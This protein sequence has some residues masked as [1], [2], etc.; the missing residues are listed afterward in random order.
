MCYVIAWRA[1]GT[2]QS[3]AI[4]GAGAMGGVFGAL[5]SEA[6][7][8]TTLIDANPQLVDTINQQGITLEE[9]AGDRT[10]R[11]PARTDIADLD[12]PDAVLFFVKCQHT[13]AAAETAR[14]LVADGT[15]VVTL[16]NGWGNAEVLTGA[17][18]EERVVVGVTYTS[19]TTIAPARI[20]TSGPARTVVG[21]LA[22]TR[23][24]AEPVVGALESAG[25]PV[26]HPEDVLT[27][28]WKK[29]VLNAATLPTAALTGLTAGALAGSDDMRWLVDAAAAEAVTVGQALGFEVELEERLQ[30]IHA[31]LER[32]GGGK[33]SMLQD[34]EAG[35]ATEIDVISGAV[36]NKAREAGVEVPVT[37]A[38]YALV[39]GLERV[40]GQR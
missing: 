3:F 31:V 13:Q 38:L 4:V 18:G 17:Y 22:G 29:L 27:E 2:N 40:R 32:A 9:V 10:I 21:A 5:L 12:P 19:A 39:T 16:Q 8:A 14:A 33:G 15:R 37:H 20:R 11:V 23:S 7:V 34:V 1:M 35:R 28:V 6:G 25:F 36:L 24:L 26:E 30:S